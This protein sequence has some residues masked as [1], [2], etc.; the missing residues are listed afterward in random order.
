MKFV[1][2][3]GLYFISFDITF[4]Y[5]GQDRTGFILACYTSSR[6][7]S[8]EHISNTSNDPVSAG[9]RHSL[10]SVLSDRESAVMASG[11]IA[12]TMERVGYTCARWEIPPR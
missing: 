4:I 8:P 3:E 1:F 7:V 5:S 9:V 11:W 10:E 2:I 6:G 12:T